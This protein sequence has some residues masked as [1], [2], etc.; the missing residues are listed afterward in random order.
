MSLLIATNKNTGQHLISFQ[1]CNSHWK[2][3]VMLLEGQLL[4]IFPSLFS[5]ATITLYRWSSMEILLNHLWTLLKL[6]T[7]FLGRAAGT[8]QPWSFFLYPLDSQPLLIPFLHLWH[9]ELQFS[10]HFCKPIG[11]EHLRKRHVFLTFLYQ[12]QRLQ[13]CCTATRDI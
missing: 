7:L 9:C 11:P 2:H 8:N 1:C 12:K 13:L 5:A 4:R 10:F 6:S 3:L